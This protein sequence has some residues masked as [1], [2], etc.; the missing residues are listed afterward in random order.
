MIIEIKGTNS[1][2]KGAE[3]MLLTTLQEIKKDKIKFTIAPNLKTSPYSF[4]SMLGI[5][6]KIWFSYKGIQFGKLGKLI[7]KK[8]RDLFGLIIDDEI[9]IILDASG[10]A[11]SSQWG[12]IPTRTMSKEVKRWRNMG[13]KIILLPQAFGP[14]DNEEIKQDMKE[15][16]KYSN[17]IYAR[18]SLSY[19]VLLDLKND[20][21][22]IKLSPDFT[23]LFKGEKPNY[24]DSTLH[25]VC[26]V[27]NQ[28]MKDKQNTSDNYEKL[29][30]NIILKLQNHQLS[31]FFLIHGG[32][33]DEILAKNINSYLETKIEIIIEEN[34]YY[35][36][37]IIENSIGLIGSRFHSLASALYSGVPTLGMGWSHK[38]LYLFQ[39]F[40]FQEGIIE[41]KI[42][43]KELD[44]KLNL[45][46]N[47][48][49]RTAINS[50]LLKKKEEIKDK[51]LE[52]FQNIKTIIGI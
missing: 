31:P 51:N 24:F 8:I 34:P 45:I 18:D 15:I 11:Y 4:Y 46:I 12:N 22:K 7:P 13:K 42:K 47:K 19:E 40:N 2:N 9:D 10:F 29:F 1:M 41:T 37:G 35:I 27:P 30:A 6:P 49:K 25:Q 33:E 3:M 16:I 20:T 50:K 14:F 36:K 21:N 23:A 38:Y 39:E 26:I 17:L 5:Y 52:F 28:R 48:D 43:D 32:K 44:K